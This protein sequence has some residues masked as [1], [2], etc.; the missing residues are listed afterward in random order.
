MVKKQAF[1][2]L[3][4][5][6]I[7]VFALGIIVGRSVSNPELSDVN[8]FIKQSEL[9]T[10][11]YLIEQDLFSDFEK[12]CGLAQYRLSTLSDE[13]WQLGKLLGSQTAREDLGAENYDFLKRK[14]HLMQIKTYT[15]YH[16]LNQDC[17]VGVPVILFYYSR[18]DSDSMEQGKI[19]DRLVQE[20]DVK[21]FA[22]EYNYSQ[23]LRFLEDYYEIAR[24]PAV[25]V[26]FDAVRQGLNSY[27][28]LAMLVRENREG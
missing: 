5:L 3:V 20:L 21:V 1:A 28:S 4:L 2:S 10:E 12:N 7:I 26:Q 22:L 15:L 23:E 24:T 8:R 14:F 17:D 18:D 16:R 11:S 27:E 6:V 25:V 19:L 13:L 9:T